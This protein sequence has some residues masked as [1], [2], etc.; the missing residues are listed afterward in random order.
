[1]SSDN[2]YNADN[3]Q[4]ATL[5][6]PAE[7]G[8][9][10]KFK[11]YRRH[12]V[13]AIVRGVTSPARFV[14]QSAPVGFGKSVTVIMQAVLRGKRAVVLTATKGLQDQC[15][16]EFASMGLVDQRGR[17]NYAYPPDPTLSCESGPCM[18]GIACALRGTGCPYDAAVTQF[19][20]ARIAVTNY[21]WWLACAGNPKIV[22]PELLILDEAHDAPAQLENVLAF[23]LS[24]A[25]IRVH[26]TPPPDTPVDEFFAD[27]AWAMWARHAH[28]TL[29]QR[30]QGLQ[31]QAR[32][33]RGNV[34]IA[35][36]LRT[37]QTLMRN[38]ALLGTAGP[39]CLWVYE[40]VNAPGG[41]IFN[42]LHPAQ[43]AERVLFQS[44]PDVLLTSGTMTPKTLHTLG[45]TPTNTDYQDYPSPFDPTRAPI[46]QWTTGI[47]WDHRT[48][49]QDVR[50]MIAMM[51]NAIGRRLD[52]KGIIHSVSYAR[53]RQILDNSQ[54]VA[55]MV[56][57]QR[58]Q[59]GDNTQDTAA[60]PVIAAF[61]AAP[62]PCVLASPTVTTG[63]DF[64]GSE[65]EY[66]IICKLP[67]PD[68]SARIM[69]ARAKADPEYAAHLC[70]VELQQMC[71]RGMRGPTDQCETLIMDDHSR[72]FLRKYRHL[73]NS[74]FWHFVKY[75]DSVPVPP[76]PL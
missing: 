4:T 8:L 27:E 5:P 50:Y 74:S 11:T 47:R 17:D 64:P 75:I 15:L 63:W 49:A 45:L 16:R 9:P 61:K 14:A 28:A 20:R 26:L 65:C 53:Q 70:A 60:A 36:L 52:R 18:G 31:D 1:M 55:V 76:P 25:D 19:N 43:F 32:Q 35:K 13:A 41:W 29:A 56:H 23:Q 66:Q 51:D 69:R 67:F 68:A 24:D 30:A 44:V 62:P 12:Q 48:D 37:T 22:T 3:P 10:S 46:Y 40:R 71:G 2:V 72:W 34:R 42:P 58:R 21:A 59:K 57:N 39:E 7:F 54:H 73:F 33:T 38:M 6:P